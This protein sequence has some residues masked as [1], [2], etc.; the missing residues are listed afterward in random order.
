MMLANADAA[1]NLAVKDLGRARQFYEEVLGLKPVAEEDPEFVAYRSGNSTINVYRS[2]FAG[3][4]KATAISWEVDDVNEVVRDLKAKGVAFEHYNLT[5]LR[6]EGDV[7]V[8]EE[9]HM[10]TAWFKDP[11]GNILNVV[12]N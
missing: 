12:A 3:T 2:E 7:H 11:D 5:G 9:G 4:N 1:A 10:R 6:Q 8:A